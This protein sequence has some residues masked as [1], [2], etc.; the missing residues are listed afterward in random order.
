M[1]YVHILQPAS[2]T[3]WLYCYMDLDLDLDCADQVSP[4]LVATTFEPF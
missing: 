1:H 3:Q 4:G 2:Y